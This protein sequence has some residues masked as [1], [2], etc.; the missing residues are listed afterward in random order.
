MSGGPVFDGAGRLAGIFIS[1]SRSA[2]S[3]EAT[4]AYNIA[5]LKD[6]SPGLDRASSRR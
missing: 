5:S 3:E 1:V 2:D 6:L 4:H